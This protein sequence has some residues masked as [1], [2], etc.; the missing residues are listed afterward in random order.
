MGDDVPSIHELAEQIAAEFVRRLFPSLRLPA[1]L[2][3]PNDESAE[4]CRTAI[5]AAAKKKVKTE[6]IDLNP[7]P[8]ARLNNVT[9][10][11]RD[12][13]DRTNGDMHPWPTLLILDGFDLLEGHKNDAPTFPLAIYLP[14]A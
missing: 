1:Y 7:A 5:A 13:N 10:R 6:L 3:C 14:L 11:L 12:I 9:A 4:C 8:T 2:A